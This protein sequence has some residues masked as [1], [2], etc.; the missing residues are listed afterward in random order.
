LERQL[1]YFEYVDR[2]A[3]AVVKHLTDRRHGIFLAA[4]K[5][6]A[7]EAERLR[8]RLHI[9]VAGFDIGRDI[10]VDV[11]P[12]RDKGYAIYLPI[13][14][15]AAKQEDLFPSMQAELEV[16]ELSPNPPLTQIAILGRYRPPM[17]VFGAIGDAMLG[18]RLAEATVRHFIIDV[19]AR[20][21][22]Q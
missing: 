10:V 11:G 3:A 14:W 15:H 8:E 2:D 21:E 17:G 9:D 1:Y 7:A 4:T 16:T 12:P 5:T 22:S 19:A 13:E 18:H 6:A 20:L